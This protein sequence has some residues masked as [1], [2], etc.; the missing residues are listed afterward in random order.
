MGMKMRMTLILVICSLLSVATLLGQ[1]TNKPRIGNITVLPSDP[2]PTTGNCTTSRAG[3]LE[4]GGRTNMTKAEIGEFVDSS[5]RDGYILTIYPQTKS[6]I[7]VN[8][9]CIAEKNPAASK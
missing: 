2:I 8:M 6:G 5:L 4:K 7:F 3:Y 9:E 1:D